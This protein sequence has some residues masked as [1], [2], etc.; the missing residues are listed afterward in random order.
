MTEAPI[1]IVAAAAREAAAVRR[2]LRV[3]RRGRGIAYEYVP[4]D[5]EGAY[6][7]WE[8]EAGRYPLV[9]IRSGIGPRRAGRAA[10]VA[11]VEF[12]PRALLA[13]GLAGA[14]RADLRPGALIVAER[15]C[16]GGADGPGLVTVAADA[17]L[18]RAAVA[19]G[20]ALGIPTACGT[21]I[22]A[23][24]LAAT[25]GAKA[26]LAAST[27]AVAVDMEAG[28]VA[29]VASRARLP[30]LAAK[31]VFD[32]ADEPLHPALLQVV[33]PDGTPRILRAAHLAVRD[34]EV[35]AALH[36]AGRRSREAARILTRFCRAF[37]PRLHDRI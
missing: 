16:P 15:T 10:E 28:G 7:W 24:A 8:G 30:F 19:A 20:E 22:T 1:V 2:A 33:R 26:V 4:T 25:P 37:L 35:R 31:I 12:R 27:G 29:T 3:P 5:T 21:L 6:R 11:C 17:G 36:W 34:P 13:L 32:A 23:P 9:L 14:L 18:V